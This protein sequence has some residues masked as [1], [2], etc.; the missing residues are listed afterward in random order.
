MSVIYD[1]VLFGVINFKLRTFSIYNKR[2]YLKIL[3]TMGTSHM[4]DK[5]SQLAK[6]NMQDGLTTVFSIF[7]SIAEGQEI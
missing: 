2:I 5:R 6:E 4:R 7:N 3:L 1:F